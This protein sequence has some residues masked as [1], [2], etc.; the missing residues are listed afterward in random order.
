MGEQEREFVSRVVVFDDDGRREIAQE[1]GQ[2]RL[3]HI[4]ERESLFGSGELEHARRAGRR[5]FALETQRYIGAVAADQADRER[6]QKR[7][8]LRRARGR[9]GVA[10]ALRQRDCI[11]LTVDVISRLHRHARRA[12]LAVPALELRKVA[13]VCIGERE[14]EVVA[15]DGLLVVPFEVQVH[16]APEAIA[17][18]ERLNHP[19]DFRAFPIDGRRVEVVDLD[20]ALGAHWVRHRAGIL[21]ELYL[22]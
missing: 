5:A 6:D 10:I 18:E 1:R 3:T 13:A 11:A 7:S 20:V 14:A 2:R 8:L 17:A 12:R 9:S 15:G 4:D 16:T 22:A 19:H 21:G